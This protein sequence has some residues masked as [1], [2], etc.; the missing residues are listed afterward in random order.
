M[1]TDMGPVD[2]S[3]GPADQS[4]GLVDLGMP[5]SGKVCSPS[6]WCWENPLPDG[7]DLYG[8]WG[9]TPTTSGPSAI[10]GT[11]LKWNGTAWAAQTSGTTNNLYGVWGADANNV[12]AVGNR[13]TILKW[14]GTA[15]AAQTSGTASAL[16]ASGERTPTTSGP[17][18]LSGTIVKWNGT[19]W[20][21]QAS[22]TTAPSMASG[23]R[24]QQRL[25]RG[26]WRDDPEV[27]RHGL[28]RPG[29]RHHDNLYG[30]WGA[31]A[32]NVWA[33]GVLGDDSEV[34]RDGLG[35]AAQRHHERPLWRVGNGR[36]Q[37]L[38]RRRFGAIVKWNG[39]A[40]A[41]QPSGL[42]EG[43]HARVGQRRQQRLGRGSDWGRL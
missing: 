25:G 41:A 18:G 13:G 36:Q 14:N 19:A 11:I 32:N 6:G 10:G 15:W 12:W 17:W 1:G 9:A 24:R 21:A 28:G 27:E 38:G 4:T 30:V 37:C 5:G 22:G 29:Q 20:A 8:V 42:P 33:V 31:D 35:R 39:T 7:I 26:R 23:E 2:L 16:M 3:M 43:L 34:E 40:W